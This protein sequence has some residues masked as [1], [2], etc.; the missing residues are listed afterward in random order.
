MRKPAKIIIGYLILAIPV[1]ILID[2]RLIILER[3]F[4]TY[5]PNGNSHR[6]GGTADVV[7]W[8]SI[9]GL[10]FIVMLIAKI[11]G[12]PARRRDRRRWNHQCPRCGYSTVGNKSGI[13]PE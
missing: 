10:V 2:V 7:M 11:L 12:I 8:A 13:C 3:V 6:L 1:G 4:P 9:G 5:N